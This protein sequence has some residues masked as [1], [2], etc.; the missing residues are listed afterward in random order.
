MAGGESFVADGVDAFLA[1]EGGD[2]GL[3]LVFVVEVD[4]GGEVGFEVFG[5]AGGETEA[6]FGEDFER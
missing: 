1:V 2:A 4:E 3:V 5:L 6:F